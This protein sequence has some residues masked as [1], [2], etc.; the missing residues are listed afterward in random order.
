M[1]AKESSKRSLAKTVSWQLVHMTL[2]YGTVYLLTGE[3][4]I[5]GA[6][7]ILELVWESVAYFIHERIWAR[8]GWLSQK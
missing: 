5:A 2:V 7:A 8:I 1:K 4:E 3:W 6:A